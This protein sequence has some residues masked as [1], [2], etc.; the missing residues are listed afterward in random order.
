MESVNIK[1]SCTCGWQGEPYIKHTYME[2]AGAAFQ[3]CTLHIASHHCRSCG[4]QLDSSEAVIRNS[5]L[6]PE[7]KQDL[8][9]K[10]MPLPHE[11]NTRKYQLEIFE[12]KFTIYSLDITDATRTKHIFRSKNKVECIGDIFYDIV[13]HPI[14]PGD[15]FNVEYR[16]TDSEIDAFCE[17]F[18][19]HFTV[20]TI[21]KRRFPQIPLPTPL[22]PIPRNPYTNPFDPT[23]APWKQD[24]NISPT[25]Y[26]FPTPKKIYPYAGTNDEKE[27]DEDGYNNTGSYID[28]FGKTILDELKSYLDNKNK[29]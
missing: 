23:Q 19:E 10:S 16:I 3:D 6:N 12:D 29:K 4:Q 26:T 22:N 8:G 2:K 25:P 15:S 5:E 17:Y 11:F 14:I 13:L 18:L 27:I 9:I 7:E 20:N 1:Y 24:P 21:D 28:D